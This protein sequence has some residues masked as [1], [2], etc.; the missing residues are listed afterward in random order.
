MAKWSGF[1]FF[2]SFALAG[3]AVASGYSAPTWGG[4]RSIGLAG[5]FVG[6]ADDATAVWHNPSGL[7]YVEGEH[8]YYIG[9]ETTHVTRLEYTPMGGAVEE[10]DNKFYPVPTL[11]YVNR[12]IP[13]LSLG[14]GGVFT[15]ASGGSFANPSANPLVNPDEGVLYSM[16]LIAAAAYKVTDFLSISAS[17]R[18]VRNALEAEGLTTVLSASPLVTDTATDLEVNGWAW[19]GAFGLTVKP[20]DWLQ[21]GAHYRTKLNFDLD[22]DVSLANSGNTDITLDQTLPAILRA[23]FSAQ[24]HPKWLFSFQYDYE[25][26]DQVDEI[27]VSSPGG[28]FPAIPQNFENTHTYHVGVEYSPSDKAS[29]LAGYAKDF[30]N[31]IPDPVVNRVFGDVKAREYAAGFEYQ[32]SDS[33]RGAFTYHA[34]VGDRNIGP[35]PGVLQP[36]E[37]DAWVSKFVL[38]VTGTL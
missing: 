29:I 34:R 28:A 37:T 20:N 31:A 25:Y 12:S 10:G 7:S 17:L 1:V 8:L 27:G 35:N 19:G 38:G 30:N 13:N 4:A 14:F 33:L 23:G 5:A 36:S 21:I 3:N 15:Y 16:E 24:A 9:L 11:A 2:I 26:N 32:L 18:R 6:L 22:G